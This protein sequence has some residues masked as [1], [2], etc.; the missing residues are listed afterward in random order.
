MND[1]LSA[2]ALLR[3]AAA[4]QDPRNLRAHEIGIPAEAI[5]LCALL[6]QVHDGPFD[7]AQAAIVLVGIYY[8]RL[9]GGAAV[10]AI[11]TLVVA[12]VLGWY[13]LWPF[14]AALLAF[15]WLVQLVG[16]AREDN[17]PAFLANRESLLLGP[18]FVVSTLLARRST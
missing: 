5:A 6:R 3:Y 18:L 9:V 10:P 15:G 14:A 8:V 12:Y 13:L 1:P 7:L 4:H 2:P 16:H 17:R 11:A